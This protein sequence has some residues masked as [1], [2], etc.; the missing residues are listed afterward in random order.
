M[1]VHPTKNHV[2]L[3][4]QAGRV[5]L[6]NPFNGEI[7]DSFTPVLTTTIANLSYNPNGSVLAINTAGSLVLWDTIQEQALGKPIAATSAAPKFSADGQ[8]LL[9]VHGESFEVLDVNTL[10][11]K[12]EPLQRWGNSRLMM[13]VD[14]H[15]SGHFIVSCYKTGEVLL[16]DTRSIPRVGTVLPTNNVPDSFVDETTLA[17]VSANGAVEFWDI[18]SREMLT[19]T[20]D[21]SDPDLRQFVF[22][23][24][25]TVAATYV[26]TNGIN[27][28]SLLDPIS[29]QPISQPITQTTFIN[30]LDLNSKGTVLA[31]GDE[32]GVLRLWDTSTSSL[33]KEPISDH[34]RRILVVKF[35]PD[36]EIIATGGH[37][38][39][40]VRDAATLQPIIEPILIEADDLVFHP[41]LPI[42][43]S[44]KHGGFP[45][46]MWDYTNGNFLGEIMSNDELSQFSFNPNG[47]LAASS[48]MEYINYGSR[49]F[50]MA[51]RD[52][53]SL[54]Q[55]GPDLGIYWYPVFNSEGN[56]LA[57]S[58][59]TSPDNNKITVW[60]L[61]V[62]FW[63]D[64]ICRTVNRNLTEKE[65]NLYFA[66]QLYRET[67]PLSPK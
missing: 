40:F 56:F 53:A 24:D 18:S 66:G 31:T 39:I 42:L 38:E 67:C 4:T 14:L 59:R 63:I 5:D 55:I 19:Q 52:G 57:S 26:Y 37:Y 12:S 43:V 16:W 58:Y 8:S 27:I 47:Q 41:T 6:W 10:E 9:I 3:S 30:S 1:T 44:I 23:D 20:S 2:A 54:Q 29:N 60:N 64:Q 32:D 49:G 15:P 35:S 46:Y 33:I 25:Y 21:F 7:E 62:E 22:N 17:A 65:W 50:Y 48:H 34:T 11:S 28:I 36:D 51:L 13:N 61:D 45:I